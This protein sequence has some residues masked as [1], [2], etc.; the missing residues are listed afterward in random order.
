[1]RIHKETLIV[2][3]VIIV[4][5]F[6]QTVLSIYKQDLG[7]PTLNDR[8]RFEDFSAAKKEIY[9]GDRITATFKSTYH[10][11]GIVEVR[12]YNFK[13][14]SDD[15][16]TFRIKEKGQSDWYYQANYKTDQFQ[17]DQLF[18]FG[19]P[20]IRDSQNKEYEFEIISLRGNEENNVGVSDTFPSFVGK[21]IYTRSEL[22]NKEALI[23]FLT[24]KF[25]NVIT[26]TNILIHSVAYVIPFIIYTQIKNFLFFKKLKNFFTSNVKGA[27][28]IIVLSILFEIILGYQSYNGFFLSILLLWFLIIRRYRLTYRDSAVMSAFLIIGVPFLMVLGFNKA[29]EKIFEWIY[30][31]FATGVIQLGLT[32]IKKIPRI[33]NLE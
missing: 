8:F 30:I 26:D 25:V 16:L 31:F 13:R 18:P 33:S 11:L 6:T 27:K 32:K 10:N 20:L 19:F 2:I 24:N 17:D 7:V 3:F 12:F 28:V 22:S 1:M 23:S 5:W 21:H 14:V 15:I 4:C 9:Q 29:A